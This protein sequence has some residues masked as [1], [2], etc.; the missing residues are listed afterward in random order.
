MP[1]H[2]HPPS[3]R[4]HAWN[5]NSSIHT[6]PMTTT[7]RIIKRGTILSPL[8]IC[9]V[10]P[11]M[12]KKYKRAD[13]PPKNETARVSER[14]SVVAFPFRRVHCRKFARTQMRTTV[15]TF[16]SIFQR[17]GSSL[18]LCLP[19]LA[20]SI[21]M[22][23]KDETRIA[24]PIIVVVGLHSFHRWWSPLYLNFRIHHTGPARCVCAMKRVVQSNKLRF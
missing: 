6:H 4:I 12:Q 9:V 19:F 10:F 22:R 18:S 11:C 2:S 7:S 21:K 5:C 20:T 16:A 1:P 8:C 13:R 23:G 24:P 14:G 3:M 17:R 15:C